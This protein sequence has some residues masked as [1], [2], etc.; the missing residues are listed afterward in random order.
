MRSLVA[1]LTS[2]EPFR[3]RETVAT[4]TPDFSASCWMVVIFGNVYGNSMGA[5]VNVYGNLVKVRPETFSVT[6]GGEPALRR[7]SRCS[8]PARRPDAERKQPERPR[9][10]ER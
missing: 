3:A 10:A 8:S 6:A 1:S 5:S 2:G 7:R 4:E 9:N